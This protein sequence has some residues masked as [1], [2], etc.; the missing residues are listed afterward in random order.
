[1]SDAEAGASIRSVNSNVR[2][3][4]DALNADAVVPMVRGV[5]VVS[6]RAMHGAGAS[7]RI[8]PS[9]FRDGPGAAVGSWRP[10]AA[11]LAEILLEVDLLGR[12][13]A[14]R[15][16]TSGTD[17]PTHRLRSWVKVAR[18]ALVSGY[19]G[20]ATGAALMY[21]GDIVSAF[22]VA[23]IARSIVAGAR[24]MPRLRERAVEALLGRFGP[25]S[26]S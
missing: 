15:L 17:V 13:A 2:Q 3:A 6:L 1:L 25:G 20:G 12:S 11:D 16:R 10:V 23:A 9:A 5:G 14:H 22:E 26:G 18:A 21:D 7:M 24:T 19:R 4:L 8:A